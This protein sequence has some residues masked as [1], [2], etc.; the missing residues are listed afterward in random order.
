MHNSSVFDL[1]LTKKTQINQQIFGILRN[2][3]FELFKYVV[4][5]DL[6]GLLFKVS[7]FCDSTDVE[8]DCGVGKVHFIFHFHAV[9]DE[10]FFNNADNRF[11]GVVFGDEVGCELN[12]IKLN[13]LKS[14]ARMIRSCSIWDRAHLEK[15]FHT[16][17]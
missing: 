6:S 13:L 9:F 3:F 16:F 14:E 12:C 10:K 5:D 4:E 17:E 1:Q 8:F 2:D 15:E 7:Q 11:F